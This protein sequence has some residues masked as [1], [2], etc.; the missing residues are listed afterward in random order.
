MKLVFRPDKCALHIVAPR[1]G[2]GVEI[3]YRVVHPCLIRVAPR[4]GAGVEIL[5]SLWRRSRRVAPRAGAGVEMGATS[6]RGTT[7][8]GRPPRGGGS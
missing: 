4:A 3:G 2:A 5:S 6:V 8:A 1:A 7:G